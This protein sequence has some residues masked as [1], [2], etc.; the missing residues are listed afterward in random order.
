LTAIGYQN[1]LLPDAL[2]KNNLKIIVVI[3][4]AVLLAAAFP[5]LV[6]KLTAHT[7][8]DPAA[9]NV[10]GRHL[11]KK[12]MAFT[13]YATP[14]AALQTI[15]WAAMMGDTDK[16]FAGLSLETQ[17]DINNKPNGRRK[18]NA[19]IKRYGQQFKGMQITARKMLADD[20]VEL[21]VKL[22]VTDS[23]KYGPPVPDFLI[24][25]FV[26]IGDDWKFNGSSRPYTPDW[27]DG[28]QPEPGAL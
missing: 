10:A 25:P 6:W 15:V 20:K 5:L 4:G 8:V 9:M 19:D 17:A 21:K 14:E 18:F 12:Q 27:D 3:V 16:A 26:R 22:D 7:A 28:S 1:R 13:G 2:L 23:S 11:A 24:M